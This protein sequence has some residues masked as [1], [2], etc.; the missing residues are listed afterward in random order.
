MGGVFLNRENFSIPSS[1]F[2]EYNYMMDSFIDGE[3]GKKCVLVFPPNLSECPN[4]FLDPNTRRSTDTYKPGG[5]EQ[6][7]D[8]TICPWCGG[9]GFR[10]TENTLS[11][12]ARVYYNPKDW[13]DVGTNIQAPDG[14][15]QIIGYMSD[16]PSFQKA[17]A[18]I[19]NSEL[20]GHEIWKYKKEG[21]AVPWGFTQRYFVQ[22]WRRIE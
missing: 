7:V 11:M 16:L 18:I 15:I 5:P 10:Q 14:I 3:P 13:I 20:Q 4:C 2:D 8:F 12:R 1:V 19:I 9:E 17:V 6:F 21:E 22:F